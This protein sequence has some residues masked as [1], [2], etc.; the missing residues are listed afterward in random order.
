MYPVHF[1][2]YANKTN[3]VVSVI[4]NVI[5]DLVVGRVYSLS[6]FDKWAIAWTRNYVHVNISPRIVATRVNGTAYTELANVSSRTYRVPGVGRNRKSNCATIKSTNQT[7]A[8][9]ESA[10]RI[11]LDNRC[12]CFLAHPRTTDRLPLDSVVGSE[13]RLFLTNACSVRF[14]HARVQPH[15]GPAGAFRP[16]GPVW[17]PNNTGGLGPFVASESRTLILFR[18]RPNAALH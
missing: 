7:T 10:S 5:A 12:F 6:P 14:V 3:R 1:S 2:G 18:P 8:D 17:S 16:V 13:S 4:R 15:V 11:R 9:V